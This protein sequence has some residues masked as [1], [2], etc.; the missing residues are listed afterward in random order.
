MTPSEL[1]AWRVR[2]TFGVFGIS[3]YLNMTQQTRTIQECYT[4]TQPDRYVFRR[5]VFDL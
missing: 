4:S 2:F 1:S 5:C 3:Q